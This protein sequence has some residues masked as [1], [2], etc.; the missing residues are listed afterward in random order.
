LLKGEAE[1]INA[2]NTPA[3][4]ANQTSVL[5]PDWMVESPGQK[6]ER[7]LAGN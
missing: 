4:D 7:I 3:L 2:Q 1:G 6:V 5:L